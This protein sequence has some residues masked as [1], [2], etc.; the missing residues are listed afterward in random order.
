M[1]FRGDV[2]KPPAFRQ[3]RWSERND[4]KAGILPS[5]AAPCQVRSDVWAPNVRPAFVSTGC[6]PV[7]LAGGAK[8][9]W[10]Q[11]LA[12]RINAVADVPDIVSSRWRVF[13]QSYARVIDKAWF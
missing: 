7:G 13:M 12:D 4:W 6:K 1:G 3:A 2:R 8:A 11:F 5:A 10:P 9:W